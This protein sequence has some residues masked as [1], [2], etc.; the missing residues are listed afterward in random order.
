SARKVATPKEH[1]DA[2]LAFLR[3][4]AGTDPCKALPEDEHEGWLELEGGLVHWKRA[5]GGRLCLHGPAQDLS[6]PAEGQIAIDVPGHGQSDPFASPRE[7]GDLP[8]TGSRPRGSA[9][10]LKDV[11]EAAADALGAEGI[12]W[13]APPAGDPDRLYPDM[14]PDRF[15][16]YLHRAWQVARAEAFFSPWYE[17]NAAHAVP[18]TPEAIATPAVHARALARIRA[19]DAARRWHETLASIQGEPR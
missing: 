8:A 17:A 16:L 3:E 7:G 15:G 13:P 12:D 2:S 9:Q 6:D 5:R 18:L 11:V 4:H 14:T 19:G 1:Q 10:G